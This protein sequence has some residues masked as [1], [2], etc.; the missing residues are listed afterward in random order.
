MIVAIV[1]HFSG[2]FNWFQFRRP[3]FALALNSCSQLLYVHKLNTLFVFMMNW[4]YIFI[5]TVQILGACNFS[6][7]H[8][9]GI[10]LWIW[11]VKPTVSISNLFLKVSCVVL[12]NVTTALVGRSSFF[13]NCCLYFPFR[14]QI[15][16]EG[17]EISH[18]LSCGQLIFH[19]RYLMHYIIL[20][21]IRIQFP[22]LEVLHVTSSLLN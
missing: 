7:H 2:L 18:L 16:L 22:W 3:T 14:P 5:L 11:K 1:F 4:C 6:I 13:F 12:L 21:F 10:V 17:P 20:E 9:F 15:C 19:P 8:L